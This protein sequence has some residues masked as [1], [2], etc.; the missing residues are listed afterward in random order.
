MALAC[1]TRSVGDFALTSTIAGAPFA[2]TCDSFFASSA[3]VVHLDLA[4]PRVARGTLAQLAVTVLASLPHGADLLAQLFDARARA[5]DRA[6]VGSGSCEQA[7]V[8]DP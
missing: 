1:A 5:Q 2:L 8:E 6:E 7:G 4:R 3:N